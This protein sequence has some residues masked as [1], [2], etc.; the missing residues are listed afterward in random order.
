M[1]RLAFAALGLG[2]V[3]ATP[4]YADEYYAVTPA[5]TTE[6]IFAGAPQDVV[7]KLSS[8]CI[9]A[10]WTV[11]SSSATELVCEA[12]MNF[13]QSLVGQLLMGNSYSTPPR[14]FFRFNA[15]TVAGVSRVQASGWME[16]QMAFGQ[17][18]R[19]D[20][21]GPEFHNGVMNFMTA[22]G[23]SFPV[24]TTF[25]N[26]AYMGFAFSGTTIGKSF[27]LQVTSVL[28]GQPAERAGLQA[29]D[30]ITSIAQK[31]LKNTEDALDAF[32][33]AAKTPTYTVDIMRAGK[34][35][36]VTVQRGYRPASADAVVA[37][38]APIAPATAPQVPSLSK[39]DE[40]SKLA[41]LKADG[42]LSQAEFDAEKAKILAR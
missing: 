12:P 23:G 42:I 16:L 11:I 41:K 30:I 10:H 32:A 36:A 29:G 34:P 6:M 37:V 3:C 15:A 5:G 13:G 4:A 14:R 1:N 21:A 39:S 18:K 9:D 17:I 8:R 38:S 2:V 19:T 26:H 7:G 33:K 40:L 27:G 25:P 31:K 20:F 28:P 24:G 22:A 35:I